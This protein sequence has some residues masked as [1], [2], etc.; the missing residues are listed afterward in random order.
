MRGVEAAVAE[1]LPRE[2][3]SGGTRQD[4]LA[5]VSSAGRAG[6][7]D[8]EGVAPR[9]PVSGVAVGAGTD[10]AEPTEPLRELG[11]PY[12]GRGQ[13]GL[14]LQQAGEAVQRPSRGLLRRPYAQQVVCSGG[15]A[16]LEQQPRGLQVIKVR[17]ALQQAVM[18][19]ALA[20]GVMGNKS[21]V[22]EGSTV[23]P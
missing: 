17:D 1:V 7:D 14:K 5:A 8:R 11:C 12:C 10:Q 22:A 3:G 20:L 18:L 23:R 6:L 13:G 15:C 21:V 2:D 4:G 9:R 16:R 19:S